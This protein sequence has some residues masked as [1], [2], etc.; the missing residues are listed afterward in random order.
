MKRDTQRRNELMNARKNEVSAKNDCATYKDILFKVVSSLQNLESDDST[1]S[2][3]SSFNIL[4]TSL[5]NT[6]AQKL[7]SMVNSQVTAKITSLSSYLEGGEFT[8][9]FESF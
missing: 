3:F 8:I 4:S 7:I 1:K 2:Q 9:E 5:G 6:E